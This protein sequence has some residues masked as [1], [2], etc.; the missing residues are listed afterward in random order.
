MPCYSLIGIFEDL[1]KGG[2]VSYLKSVSS[3][4]FLPIKNYF[5]QNTEKVFNQENQK[6]AKKWNVYLASG[7]FMCE[8]L[9]RRTAT[10]TKI[11]EL[12]YLYILDL[13]TDNTSQTIAE[14]DFQTLECA[15][16]TKEKVSYLR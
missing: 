12:N 14:K 15:T 10:L 9:K 1:N 8:K 3:E 16:F 4:E 13:S 2:V 11:N 5:I 6:Q 7:T